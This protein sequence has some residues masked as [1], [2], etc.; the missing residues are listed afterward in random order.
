MFTGIIEKTA[1]VANST[2]TDGVATLSIEKPIGWDLKVG[3]SIAVNGVCLTTV[4]FDDEKF[5]VELVSETLQKTTF[6]KGIPNLVNLERAML[7]LDRFEGHIVQ[8]HVDAVGTIS[9]M[10][11]IDGPSLLTI[12]YDSAFDHLVVGKGSVAINGISLTVVAANKGLLSVALIP[13]T[14]NHTTF[15][16]L[17]EDDMVNLEF[18]I[19]GK[20][21]V[22]QMNTK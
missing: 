16:T 8:G 19:V 15:D 17:K 10:E 4:A 13:H 1:K 7:P 3:Q 11:E 14:L 21:L 22:K 18:D 2:N 9:H 12:M 20:Y 6:G 5:Q